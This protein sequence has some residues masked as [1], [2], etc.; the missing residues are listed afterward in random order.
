MRD[1]QTL[2]VHNLAQGFDS[3]DLRTRRITRTFEVQARP[4]ANFPL[5]VAIGP[6]GE[7]HFG[8]SSGTVKISDVGGQIVQTLQHSRMFVFLRRKI[9]C[10]MRYR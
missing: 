8:T 9:G 1:D 2:V 5:P 4:D 6:S 10:G 3:Y 7:L